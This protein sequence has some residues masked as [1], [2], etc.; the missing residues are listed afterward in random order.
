MKVGG[1]GKAW[2]IANEAG[3]VNFF[4][5]SFSLVAHYFNK[6]QSKEFATSLVLNANDT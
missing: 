3:R 6:S 5:Y 1:A 4:K 2:R